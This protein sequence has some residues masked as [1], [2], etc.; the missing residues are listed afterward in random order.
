VGSTEAKLVEDKTGYIKIFVQRR[1]KDL[2]LSNIFA[3]YTYGGNYRN[4]CERVAVQCGRGLSGTGNDKVDIGELNF[5]NPLKTARLLYIVPINESK[6]LSVRDIL[7]S[8][9]ND[10]NNIHIVTHYLL[11]MSNIESTFCGECNK[12]CKN[13]HSHTGTPDVYKSDGKINLEDIN[14]LIRSDLEKVEKTNLSIHEGTRYAMVFDRYRDRIFHWTKYFEQNFLGCKFDITA[15]EPYFKISSYPIWYQNK[16]NKTKIKT[17][18]KIL[19]D[20]Q[21]SLTHRYICYLV[22]GCSFETI[23]RKDAEKH[24]CENHFIELTKDELTRMVLQS[25]NE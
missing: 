22:K 20:A 6:E 7:R 2:E 4:H 18:E 15:H 10:N 16:H 11:E 1:Y 14:T 5:K 25:I 19:K 17:L 9:N 21:N 3:I 23:N 12:V 8:N 13:K 24:M